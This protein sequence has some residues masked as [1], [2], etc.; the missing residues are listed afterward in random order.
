ML[1]AAEGEWSQRL[2]LKFLVFRSS[3]VVTILSP[4]VSDCFPAR[5]GFSQMVS[6]SFPK[7]GWPRSRSPV[8][9]EGACSPEG[10]RVT[11]TLVH[12]QVAYL[13]PSHRDLPFVMLSVRATEKQCIYSVIVMGLN[14]H[15][16]AR[17]WSFQMF[18]GVHC[19]RC[20]A[21][22][23]PRRGVSQSL[24]LTTGAPGPVPF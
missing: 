19:V 21:S 2:G 10:R 16:V 4:G 24:Q 1:R 23:T 7:G 8:I 9:Q 12:R 3:L 22:P 11:I 20:Y 17:G 15:V 14:L 13:F 5:L 6:P 18:I